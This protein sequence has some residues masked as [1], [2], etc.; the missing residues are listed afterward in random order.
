MEWMEEGK[1][2]RLPKK[3]QLFFNMSKLLFGN[4]SRM[5]VCHLESG[6]KF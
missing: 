1:E 5:A 2:A 6:R 3:R 4:M